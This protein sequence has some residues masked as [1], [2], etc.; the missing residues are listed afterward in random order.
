[1][2]VDA[3]NRESPAVLLEERDRVAIIRLNRPAQ[4]NPL[5]L[6]TLDLLE[7]AFSRCTEGDGYIAVVFT[8]AGDA[9]AS[10][11]NIREL[12]GLT[13]ESALEFA[14]RGGRLLS[15]ISESRL[16][17]VAAVNG[18]CMGGGLDL[19]LSCD[20]RVACEEAVFA[21]PGARLGII[22]GWGG[23]QRLTRLIGSARACEMFLTASRVSARDA[24]AIGL[25][26]RIAP[27]AVEC[28][29]E[30]IRRKERKSAGA[31]NSGAL[32]F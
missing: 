11:A 14:A 21:H 13:R 16:L 28:A 26:D 29:L 3:H 18:F 25:V 27:D 9:F 5:S 32:S 10:G 2:R 7:A 1:M 30:I 31:R 22:T 8:G 23:T 19:A 4:R 20:V 17:T 6:S 12:R 15:R 24:H